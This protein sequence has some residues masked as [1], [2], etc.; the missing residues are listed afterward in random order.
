MRSGAFFR[1]PHWIVDCLCS[2]LKHEANGDVSN[3]STTDVR[4]KVEFSVELYTFQGVRATHHSQSDRA[5][6]A[7]KWTLDSPVLDTPTQHLCAHM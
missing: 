6:S 7:A 2:G 1:T 4:L 3:R 5:D